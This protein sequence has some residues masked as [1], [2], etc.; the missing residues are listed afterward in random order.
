VLVERDSPPPAAGALLSRIK[1]LSKLDIAERRRPQDGRIKIT[2]GEKEL[3]LRV[4]VIPTNH[5]QSVVMRIL[6][7]D[8]IKVGVRELGLRRRLLQGLQ[9]ADPP[10]QRDHPRYRPDRVG[11][12]DHAVR[13][14]QRAEPARP[15]DHHRRGPRRVLPAGDQPG[16]GQTQYRARFRPHH[17]RHAASG[18]EYHPGRRNARSRDGIDGYSG[19]SDWTLGIQY[20]TYE[21]C[22]QCCY[23]HDRHGGPSYL[24]SSSVSR[25]W[26]N[27]LVRVV[28]QKCKE[29]WVMLY[30]DDSYRQTAAYGCQP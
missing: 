19:L 27:V 1:I 14:A 10:P 15:Q 3:D 29:Q 28:C 12:D 16:G 24:V 17:S 22:A 21:R 13:G 23:T 9:G 4:S 8:N 5:G 2:V 30:G 7:K 6:D 11:K 20:T 26:H 25:S 18:P